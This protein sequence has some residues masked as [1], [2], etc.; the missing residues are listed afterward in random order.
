MADTA[1]YKAQLEEMRTTLTEELKT[2]G[3]QNPEVPEDW[4]ATPQGVDVAQADPNVGADRVE[5]WDTRR[6]TIAQLETRYNNINRALGK[7]EAGTFGICEISG[8]EIEAD[9]LEA[10]PAARTNKANIN[11]EADLPA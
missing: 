10:N 11:N 6:A 7:I 3:I 8:E 2:L 5:D 9:R 4:Q 1:K